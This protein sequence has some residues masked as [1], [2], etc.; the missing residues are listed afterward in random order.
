LLACALRPEFLVDLFR[1][2]LVPLAYRIALL[3]SPTPR[4]NAS[5]ISRNLLPIDDEKSRCQIIRVGSS[6]LRSDSTRRSHVLGASSAFAADFQVTVFDS[7]QAREHK[8]MTRVAFL[9][10][11]QV[12]L[13]TRQK[14][15]VV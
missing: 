9:L 11:P 10:R 13:R 15:V 8:V 1:F 3:D 5:R 4:G 14:R 2:P 7:S 12:V 6:N